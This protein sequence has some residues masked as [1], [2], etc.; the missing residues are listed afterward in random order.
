MTRILV[1][2]DRVPDASLGSGYGRMIDTIDELCAIAGVEVSLYPTIGP[3]A[4]SLWP[5][6][7]PVMIV[8]EPLVPHLEAANSAKRPYD[9]VII[10]RPHNYEQVGSLIRRLLPNAPLIYDAEAL[11]F[12]RVERQASLSD[13]LSRPQLIKEAAAL[14]R[15]EERIAAEVDEIVCIAEEEAELLAPHA[16]RPVTV[17]APLLANV[18]WTEQGFDERA[19][20]GFVAGWS[21][22]PR[23]PNID[24]LQWFARHV[25]PRVRARVPSAVML[26]TAADPPSDVRRFEEPSF[27]FVGGVPDLN[28]FYG[29]LRLAVVPIRY[30]SGVKLKA[31]EALQS[32]VPTVATPVG[33]EGI[34]SEV[35]GL[36]EVTDDPT[37]FAERVAELLTDR[38]AWDRHR[39]RL[40]EQRARWDQRPPMNT[41]TDLIARV[42]VEGRA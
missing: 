24:G 32:G 41:W 7:R 4:D 23:S 1:I 40:A 33:A 28:T 19:N 29:D 35:P 15:L 14:R 5:G 12:R 16:R 13:A 34:P 8:T 2:E 36:L 22:G 39:R 37:E 11:Y 27:R 17:S 20:V 42:T 30:G 38:D 25:W 6:S 3:T 31:V 10:S 18:A 21:A 26:V 9:I